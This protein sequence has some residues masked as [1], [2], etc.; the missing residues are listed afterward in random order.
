MPTDKEVTSKIPEHRDGNG[1]PV[2]SITC[3]YGSVGVESVGVGEKTSSMNFD[4]SSDVDSL[5]VDL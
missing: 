3:A 1:R 5:H 4:L 2:A